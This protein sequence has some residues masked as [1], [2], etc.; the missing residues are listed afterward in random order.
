M[1]NQREL[2]LYV[3]YFIM[4]LVNFQD[5]HL[6]RNSKSHIAKI[7]AVQIFQFWSKTYQQPQED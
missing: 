6:N 5:D 1:I 4:M 7:N 2:F 3:V